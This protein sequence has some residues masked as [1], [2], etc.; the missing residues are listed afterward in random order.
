MT[1]NNKIKRILA[2][3]F[4]QEC[5][6]DGTLDPRTYDVDTGQWLIS[7]DELR[8]LEKSNLKVISMCVGKDNK[9]E[10]RLRAL[11]E[12]E[13]INRMVRSWL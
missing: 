10:L 1:D 2:D 7:Q 12:E 3:I 5:R 8:Q 11:W 4:C 9:L 6:I 13:S